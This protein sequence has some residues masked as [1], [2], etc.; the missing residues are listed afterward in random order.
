MPEMRGKKRFFP[1]YSDAFARRTKHPSPDSPPESGSYHYWPIPVIVLYNGIPQWAVRC[2]K[3]FTVRLMT[4]RSLE[5]RILLLCLM[6]SFHFIEDKN[7][8]EKGSR[9]SKEKNRRVVASKGVLS[10]IYSFGFFIC[11][12]FL[13]MF[14]FYCFLD[15][16]HFFQT[17]TTGSRIWATLCATIHSAY[18]ACMRARHR[19]RLCG[20]CAA[21]CISVRIEGWS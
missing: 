5:S 18:H 13:L 2:Q 11:F 4:Q 10:L 17:Q 16:L 14:L 7:I 15:V 8:Q 12:L 20:L 3:I 9:K 19:W 21:I 1:S 6:Q